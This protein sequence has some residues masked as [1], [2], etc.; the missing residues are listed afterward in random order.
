ML[1][2]LTEEQWCQGA[3]AKDTDGNTTVVNSD[4]STKKLSPQSADAAQWDL[5]G[6]CR[7]SYLSNDEF[8]KAIDELKRVYKMLYK[9]KYDKHDRNQYYKK[10]GKLV[11]L[12]EPTLYDLNDELD[13]FSQLK[14][15]L[16]YANG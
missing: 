11:Y 3:H 6:A 1:D 15:I 4:G 12:E 5:Y 10:E 8:Y 7:I 9:E 16:F 2:W 13:D 14:R